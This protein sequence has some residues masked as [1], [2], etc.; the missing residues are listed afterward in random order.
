MQHRPDAQTPRE[1]LHATPQL[2]YALMGVHAV[3]FGFCF[4][5]ILVITLPGFDKTSPV[6][7]VTD[8]GHYIPITELVSFLVVLVVSIYQRE[9]FKSCVGENI[10]RIQEL[11]VT[12]F[13]AVKACGSGQHFICATVQL[14]LLENDKIY[15]FVEFLHK[16]LS[17]HVLFGGWYAVHHLV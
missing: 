2:M 17:H 14:Q 12:C 16:I 15:R 4:S 11:T 7:Q 10:S 13:V 9:L 3:L 6:L 1:N 8:S 5:W